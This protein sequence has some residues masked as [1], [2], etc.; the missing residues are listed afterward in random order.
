MN[1]DYFPLGDKAI[2]H[3]DDA[4]KTIRKGANVFTIINGEEY[5][6]PF[7]DGF[8]AADAFNAMWVMFDEEQILRSEQLKQNKS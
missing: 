6:I 3:Y 5:N 7:D 8:K 2:I 1:R 4:P